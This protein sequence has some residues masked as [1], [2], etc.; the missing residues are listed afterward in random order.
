MNIPII[1]DNVYEGDETFLLEIIADDKTF[2]AGCPSL[3]VEIT[4]DVCCKL[5]NS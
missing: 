5:Y 3:I 1:T 4:N 2:A